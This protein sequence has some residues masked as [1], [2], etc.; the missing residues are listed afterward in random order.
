ML[1]GD[2]PDL[3]QA[4]LDE[5][6]QKY[7]GYGVNN[8][9]NTERLKFDAAMIGCK[10]KDCTIVDFGGSGDDGQSVFTNELRRLGYK[11][12]ICVNA[13]EFIP[14]NCEVIYASHVI[15]H[16][17]DLPET[18]RQFYRALSPNGKLIIDVPNA[19]GLLQRWKMPILDFNTKH[20]NH[21]TLRNLLDLGHYWDFEMVYLKQYELEVAPAFQVY[22]KL[23][24][25]AGMSAVHVGAE[26]AK[27]IAQLKDIDF[28]VNIWGMGDIVWHLLSRVDL[29]VL[30]YIDN[31]PAYRGQT[32]AGKPVLER[33]TN[34]EPIVILAQG[35]RERL[36]SNIRKMGI[37]SRIIEI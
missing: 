23:Q 6:Y 32:Y 28:P 18:M 13:G 15:E 24:S 20:I 22:F 4:I 21:F 16:I 35:Q 37:K 12:A 3:N 31:D 30:D 7:Y 25:T 34:D 19:T 27:R 8:P 29:N 2:S 36:I 14:D 1:Y 9:A 11:N 10:D 5:Y 26:T 33:P 17:Y